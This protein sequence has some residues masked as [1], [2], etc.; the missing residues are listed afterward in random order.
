M[1]IRDTI[2][3]HLTRSEVAARHENGDVLLAAARE[4]A[5]SVSIRLIRAHEDLAAC[6]M[7]NEAE[8]ARRADELHEAERVFLDIHGTTEI[9]L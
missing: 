5:D 4:M 9:E 2:A 8:F 6:D 7:D 1:K 3:S